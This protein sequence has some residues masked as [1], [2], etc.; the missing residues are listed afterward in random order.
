M[1]G[2]GARYKETKMRRCEIGIAAELLRQRKFR[3]LYAGARR[4]FLFHCRPAYV[5]DQLL[6]R[7][8]ACNKKACC[9]ARTSP[10]CVFFKEKK[11][12]LYD[13]MPFYCK[14]FPIDT[15]D[16]ELSDVADACEYYW[17]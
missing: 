1:C 12:A 2:Q 14:I 7:K 10:S 3:Y 11:C 4:R 9:C 6:K 5:I 16:K 17:D 15:K 13:D 8:G